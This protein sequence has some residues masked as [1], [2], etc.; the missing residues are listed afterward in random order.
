M[1]QFFSSINHILIF[2][3]AVLSAM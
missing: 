3:L 1:S 2:L